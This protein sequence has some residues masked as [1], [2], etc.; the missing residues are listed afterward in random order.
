MH[1]TQDSWYLNLRTKIIT[2]DGSSMEHQSGPKG[3]REKQRLNTNEADALMAQTAQIIDVARLQFKRLR[4]DLRDYRHMPPKGASVRIFG[5]HP[6]EENLTRTR[7]IRTALWADV[8]FLMISMQEAEKAIARMGNLF[9][10]E[11][12]LTKLRNKHRPLLKMC[13]EFRTHLERFDGNNGSED[14]GQLEKCVFSFHGKS[15]DLGPHFEDSTEKLFFDLMS[16]W[17][18]MSDR[19]RKIRELILRFTPPAGAQSSATGFS[20]VKAS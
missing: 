8:Y 7:E 14:F 2:E 18:L 1:D 5:T 20:R 15:I 17:T 19:Q 9:P 16:A 10:F 11:A 6:H 13:K 3:N 4:R 12:D